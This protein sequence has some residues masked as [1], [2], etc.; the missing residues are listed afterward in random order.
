M[1]CYPV[2]LLLRMGK[3][4]GIYVYAVLSAFFLPMIEEHHDAKLKFI[5]ASCS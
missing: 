5:P 4:F 3:L 2:F 1:L